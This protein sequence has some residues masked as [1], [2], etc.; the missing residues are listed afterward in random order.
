[1][2]DKDK[3]AAI[4]KHWSDEDRVYLESLEQFD[5]YEEQDH[6]EKVLRVIFPYNEITELRRIG[7]RNVLRVE[8]DDALDELNNN[9]VEGFLRLLEICDIHSVHINDG[10]VVAYDLEDYYPIKV[11]TFQGTVIF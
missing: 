4:I 2:L 5:V 11:F 1:M 6:G 7:V 8:T 9:T 3:A 10:K